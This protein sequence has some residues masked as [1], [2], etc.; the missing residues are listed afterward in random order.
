MGCGTSSSRVPENIGDV[1]NARRGQT[2]L[3]GKDGT[4]KLVDLASQE[5]KSARQ[6]AR[7]YERVK[8]KSGGGRDWMG[9]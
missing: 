1:R 2:S 6:A 9:E 3:S 7:D 5:H 8:R 4:N